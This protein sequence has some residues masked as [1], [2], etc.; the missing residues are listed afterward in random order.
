MKGQAAFWVVENTINYA[1]LKISSSFKKG[2]ERI[3][4]VSGEGSAEKEKNPKSYIYLS[5]F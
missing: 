1:M 4:E 3:M 2:V 5:F